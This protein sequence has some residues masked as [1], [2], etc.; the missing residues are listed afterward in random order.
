MATSETERFIETYKDDPEQIK[1]ILSQPVADD[2]RK[3][4]LQQY[5]AD[6]N[7]VELLLRAP[8]SNTDRL[9]VYDKDRRDAYATGYQRAKA[10]GADLRGARNYGARV[11]RLDE[12]DMKEIEKLADTNMARA[13]K[14]QAPKE[15]RG[16]IDQVLY[17]AGK[18]VK[19][20]PLTKRVTQSIDEGV[21]DVK[22]VV[23]D[24]ATDAAIDLELIPKDKRNAYRRAYTDAKDKG[25][26][27]KKTRAY[28]KDALGLSAGAM[29]TI[30][31]REDDP[32]PD[33]INKG[34]GEKLYKQLWARGHSH[35]QI[36]DI[37]KQ[38]DEPI[39][40]PSDEDLDKARR[41][42][43]MRQQQKL[44]KRERKRMTPADQ[45]AKLYGGP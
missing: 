25:E 4:L 24:T 14:G 26:D 17:D 39:F 37:L 18:A 12:S 34:R 8:T 13:A 1:R 28:G 16:T 19:R 38:A 3:R 40:R 22:R 9:P 21:D 5:K 7:M 31:T 30:E 45:A 35:K 11:L 20:A 2:A 41:M 42:E 23:S 33:D 15:E 10:A 29:K 27:L 44:E 6:P 32:S 36:E 43:L